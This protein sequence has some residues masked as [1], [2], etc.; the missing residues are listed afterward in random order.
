[1]NRFKLWIEGFAQKPHSTFA[2]FVTA[3]VESSLLPIPIDALFIPLSLA[4][5]KRAIINA[6]IC[7]LGSAIGAVVGYYIGYAL[8]ETIGVRVVNYFG[9]M[10][11][12]DTV[13]LKYKEH[14]TAALL[15][16]GFTPIPFEVFTYAAGFKQAVGLSTFIPAV[17]AGRALRF[18]PIGILLYMFGS[19]IKGFIKKYSTVLA[20]AVPF[21]LLLWFIAAK[22]L[23]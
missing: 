14:A 9:W 11:L 22:Y 1:L 15:L 4:H 23:L 12:F 19:N 16:A 2:L 18:I 7:V 17:L 20:I 3:I 5:P 21:L 6:I 10:E 13:L 8:F